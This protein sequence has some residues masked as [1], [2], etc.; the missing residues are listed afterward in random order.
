MFSNVRNTTLKKLQEIYSVNS[1][2]DYDFG[3][4]T[5]S[6]SDVAPFTIFY[7]LPGVGKTHLCKKLFNDWTIHNDLNDFIPFFLDGR[8]KNLTTENILSEFNKKD[9]ANNK[10]KKIMFI[11]NYCPRSKINFREFESRHYVF[12]LFCDLF[13]NYENA[14]KNFAVQTYNLRNEDFN[15]TI[16]SCKIDRIITVDVD[17]MLIQLLKHIVEI[18]PIISEEYNMALRSHFYKLSRSMGYDIENWDDLNIKTNFKKSKFFDLKFLNDKIFDAYDKDLSLRQNM[19]TNIIHKIN[20]F[21]KNMISPV[22]FKKFIFNLITSNLQHTYKTL[23]GEFQNIS[24]DVVDQFTRINGV[25]S[26]LNDTLDFNRFES[27]DYETNIFLD[28]L[29]QYVELWYITHNNYSL[30]CIDSELVRI[31]KIKLKKESNGLPT[32]SEKY[33]P[34]KRG[35]N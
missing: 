14:K 17:V 9:F 23:G 4:T 24:G 16:M 30:G 5:K 12:V 15:N 35:T 3:W 6:I 7:G 18:D 11:D 32:T 8:D 21:F 26:I 33:V 1:T 2:W 19:T 28:K 29:T 31:M 13:Y 25:R 27:I 34:Y 22:I 10:C 20:V